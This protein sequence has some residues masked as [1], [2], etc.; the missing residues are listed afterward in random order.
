MTTGCIIRMCLAGWIGLM[1]CSAPSW[2]QSAGFKLAI[3]DNQSVSNN[4]VLYTFTND[5][6]IITAL[7]DNGRTPVKYLARSL[8]KQESRKLQRFFVTF[9]VDSLDDLY[10]DPFNP[11]APENAGRTARIIEI[12]IQS[13]KRNHRYISNNCWVGYTGRIIDAVNPFLPQ[14]TRITYEKSAFNAFY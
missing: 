2:A 9:P 1:V 7:S 14:E 11:M 5:S 12:D 4:H 3:S 13:G 8:S 6:L 10:L